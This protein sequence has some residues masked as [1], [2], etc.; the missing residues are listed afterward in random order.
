MEKD[1][2]FLGGNW[3]RLRGKL[4]CGSAQPSLF[5]FIF[6]TEN[7]QKWTP[8]S[9]NAQCVVQKELLQ[10][11]TMELSPVTLAGHFLEKFRNES[12]LQ[13]VNFNLNVQ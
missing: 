8:Y 10:G 2:E 1:Y 11:S 4:E 13:D 5:I 6:Q 12:N 7:R 9:Q 3:G